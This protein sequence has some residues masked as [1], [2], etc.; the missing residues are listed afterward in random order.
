MPLYN[1]SPD[2]GERIKENLM[3]GIPSHTQRCK[4]YVGFPV[5]PCGEWALPLGAS[6]SPPLWSTATAKG[7]H[8]YSLHTEIENFLGYIR[9]RREEALARAD[10]LDRFTSLVEQL[11]PGASLQPF[12]SSITGL[13]F[14]TSDIDIAVT[15]PPSEAPNALALIPAA[16]QSLADLE[17]KLR[18]SGFAGKIEPILR[19]STPLL[20]VTDAMTGIQIDLT[21]SSDDH[22]IRSTKV[23]LRWLEGEDGA[24]IKSLVKVLKVLLATRRLGTT[25]TGGVNSYLL[26]LMVIVWVTL[27]LPMMVAPFS[28]RVLNPVLEELRRQGNP[29]AECLSPPEASSWKGVNLGFALKALLK[30][31]GQDF[32]ASTKTIR[33][34]PATGFFYGTKAARSPNAIQGFLLSISDPADPSIDV[35]AKAY[36]IKHVQ[37]SFMDAWQTLRRVE[38]GTGVTKIAEWRN[39]NVRGILAYALGGDYSTMEDK[40]KR[41]CGKLDV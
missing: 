20:R 24:L 33:Y 17:V 39:V 7:V 28:H 2:V 32:D 29:F 1:T 16:R 5:P 15:F 27:E 38:S 30:F 23:L 40:R 35:G 18:E 11:S 41:M 14:P 37:A 34:T 21:A 19:A 6:I 9:P 4:D 26:T 13:N 25:F 10:L 8:P 31:Y 3:N 22:G 36:A 12:G